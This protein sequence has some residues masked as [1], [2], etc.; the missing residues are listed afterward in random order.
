MFFSY[1]VEY[2]TWRALVQQLWH[3]WAH[4][5]ISSLRPTHSK[6]NIDSQPAVILYATV[7]QLFRYPILKYKQTTKDHQTFEKSLQP[8]K[9]K[10]NIKVE[11]N[12]RGK[13]DN[14]RKRT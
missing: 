9:E 10:S 8:E 12:L 7:C 1:K 4:G 2:I 11:N 13:K 6:A 14:S 5:V 3:L